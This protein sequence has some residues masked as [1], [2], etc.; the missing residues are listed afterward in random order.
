[1][2]SFARSASA[3]LTSRSI[4][5]YQLCSPRSKVAQWIGTYWNLADGSGVDL[6]QEGSL[7]GNRNE[8]YLK[9]PAAEAIAAGP[10]VGLIFAVFL[11]FI[12]IAMT[13]ALIGRKLGEGVAAAAAGSMSFRW[14]PIEAY[15]AGRKRKNEAREKKSDHAAKKARQQTRMTLIKAGPVADSRLFYGRR[16]EM[17]PPFIRSRS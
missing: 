11:P 16:R 7:P 13:L 4:G 14:R 9:A 15:L 8:M 2:T 12:G 5:S 10:V 1:V 3:V 17:V 6:E